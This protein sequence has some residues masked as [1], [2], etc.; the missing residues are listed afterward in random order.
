MHIAICDDER[1]WHEVLLKLLREYSGKRQLD[2]YTQSFANGKA[3]A[4]SNKKFDIIFMDYRMKGINGI[5]TARRIREVSPESVIIFVSSHTDV[6][7]DTFEVK[8]YRFLAKP[9]NRS[10][11]F[12]ALDDYRAEIDL[13]SFLIYKTHDMTLRIRISDIIYVEAAKNHA[14]IHTASEAYEVVKNLKQ[15]YND[16][17]KDKFYR[18]QKSYVVSFLHIR[19]HDKEEIYLDDGRSVKISRNSIRDFRNSFQEYILK[20]NTGDV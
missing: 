8:A 10:K 14:I 2:I 11:L 1:V 19:A 16:L 9:I 12:K 15:V 13:D 5:E 20:Y 18:C 3:L 6:A 7:I 4:E 17:P